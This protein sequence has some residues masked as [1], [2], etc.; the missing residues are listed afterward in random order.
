MKLRFIFPIVLVMVAG[1]AAAQ[2]N[3]NPLKDD[4]EIV[5]DTLHVKSGKEAELARAGA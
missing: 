4:P 1:T 5:V 2:E 3:T